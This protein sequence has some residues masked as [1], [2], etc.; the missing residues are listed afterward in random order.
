MGTLNQA[1]QAGSHHLQGMFYWHCNLPVIPY[2]WLTHL[3][4]L[5]S[6]DKVFLSAHCMALSFYLMWLAQLSSSFLKHSKDR[7]VRHCIQW[8]LQL[9]SAVTCFSSLAT[10]WHYRNEIWL[11]DQLFM[12]S[13]D[14]H[15]VLNMK[16][17]DS[18]EL[19]FLGHDIK[20][21]VFFFYEE[22]DYMWNGGTQAR[23]GKKFKWVLHYFFWHKNIWCNCSSVC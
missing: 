20:L 6:S 8:T 7:T 12:L 22:A 11:T 14:L 19:S 15:V 3:H 13:I 23:T 10:Y 9:A 18:F 17:E 2:Q 4:V 1:H 5:R 21:D 16:V